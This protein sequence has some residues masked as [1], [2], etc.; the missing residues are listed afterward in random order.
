MIRPSVPTLNPVLQNATRL[1]VLAYLSACREAEFGTVRDH[2][3]VS[4]PTLSKAVAQLEA[5]KYL[6]VKKGYL[7]KY[8]RTWL[9]GTATGRAALNAHLQALEDIVAAAQRAGAAAEPNPSR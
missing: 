6:R 5:A 7:G 3:G 4:D 9:A 8:P 2:C 1:T